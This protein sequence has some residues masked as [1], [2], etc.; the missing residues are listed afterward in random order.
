MNLSNML[1]ALFARVSNSNSKRNLANKYRWSVENGQESKNERQET[2]NF[3]EKFKVQFYNKHIRLDTLNCTS[4]LST[5][6]FPI[7]YEIIFIAR[8]RGE[9]LTMNSTAYMK[10]V[11][12]EKPLSFDW[13]V[14]RNKRNTQSDVKG[15]IFANQNKRNRRIWK[16]I[17]VAMAEILEEFDQPS[18][19][20]V[21]FCQQIPLDEYDERSAE[22]T[23]EALHGL[24]DHLDS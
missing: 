20:T 21:G 13:F 11:A 14:R 2:N 5:A 22:T 3:H 4:L 10:I 8:T 17:T 18:P 24:L 19:C 23:Q 15:A 7:N 6:I 1:I 16:I 9:K 12:S